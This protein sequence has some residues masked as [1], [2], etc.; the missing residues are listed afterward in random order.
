MIFRQDQRS[1][2][3]LFTIQ[4]FCILLFCDIGAQMFLSV[5]HDIQTGCSQSEQTHAA[6]PSSPDEHRQSMK[7]L[8]FRDNLLFEHNQTSTCVAR[9]ISGRVTLL[10]STARPEN[11][12]QDGTADHLEYFPE[13]FDQIPRGLSWCVLRS[14]MSPSCSG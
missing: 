12:F 7:S 5:A 2:Y 13:R 9:P 8:R 14:Q 6:D 10:V 3:C 1:K 4:F 11:R